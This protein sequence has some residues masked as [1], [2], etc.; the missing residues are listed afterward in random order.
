MTVVHPHYFDDIIGK[1]RRDGVQVNHFTLCVSKETL[2]QRLR[3]RG[4]GRQSWAARQVERCIDG[5][6]NEKFQQHLQTDHLSIEQVAEQIASMSSISL[7]PDNRGKL[8]K[9]WARMITKIK[10]FRFF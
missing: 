10:H 8:S 3:S 2:M 9:V 7:L 1:L 4:E 5:L 6:S